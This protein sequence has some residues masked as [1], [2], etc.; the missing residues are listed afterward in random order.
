MSIN[1]IIKFIIIAI[2]VAYLS[3]SL[4]KSVGGKSSTGTSSSSSAASTGSS[5]CSSALVGRCTSIFQQ[6]IF[7]NA[8]ASSVLKKPWFRYGFTKGFF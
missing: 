8:P 1:R 7:R 3:K 5:G 6:N 2:V 4:I